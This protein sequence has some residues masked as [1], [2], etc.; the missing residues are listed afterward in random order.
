MRLS[1]CANN[2][3]YFALSSR[4]FYLIF[5]RRFKDTPASTDGVASAALWRPRTSRRLQEEIAFAASSRW[6]VSGSFR[7]ALGCA[8]SMGDWH[9]NEPWKL[10]QRV[11]GRGH[12]ESGVSADVALGEMAKY[13]RKKRHRRWGAL[14]SGRLLPLAADNIEYPMENSLIRLLLFYR[15]SW[16]STQRRPTLE[17]STRPG[18]QFNPRGERCLFLIMTLKQ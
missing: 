15:A 13:R 14:R 18:V 2:T 7:D 12:G 9:M 10:E 17:T 1:T 3:L 4:F 16:W 11:V 5:I 6:D 8:L